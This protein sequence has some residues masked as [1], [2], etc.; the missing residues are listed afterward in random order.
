MYTTCNKDQSYQSMPSEQNIESTSIE[1]VEAKDEVLYTDMLSDPANF[2]IESKDHYKPE[3]Y[4]YRKEKYQLVNTVEEFEELLRNHEIEQYTKYN[5]IKTNGSFTGSGDDPAAK[6]RIHWGALTKVSSELA[7]TPYLIVA[8]RYYVCHL[9]K[10][11]YT[12]K[13]QKFSSET[14]KSSKRRYKKTTDSKKVGCPACFKVQRLIVFIDN[15][16]S[17]D[18]KSERARMGEYI[19]RNITSVKLEH[20][21]LFKF[22][23]KC[24]HVNHVENRI[25]ATKEPIDKAILDKIRNLVFSGITS[26]SVIS[27]SLQC[28]VESHIKVNDKNRRRFFPSR[29]DIRRCVQKAR[30]SL[31]KSKYDEAKLI[32]IK[33]TLGDANTFYFQPALYSSDHSEDLTCKKTGFLIVYQ[34]EEMKRLYNLYGHHC[35]LLDPVYKFCKYSFVLYFLIIQT[36]V[37]YQVIGVFL[38][39][40]ESKDSII[41]ALTVIF[42][43]NP[44]VIPKYAMTD[45]NVENIKALESFFSDIKVF[46]PMHYCE[47]SWNERFRKKDMLSVDK[48]EALNKMKNI[49]NAVTEDKVQ[50]AINDMK[51][52]SSPLKDYFEK[53]WQKELKKWTIA[54]RPNDLMFESNEAV[55]RLHEELYYLQLSKVRE[56]TLSEVVTYLCKDLIP[57]ML[58]RYK[59]FNLVIARNHLTSVYN[60]PYLTKSPQWFL[61]FMLG[62][63]LLA[64]KLL[65]FSYVESLGDENFS[66]LCKKSNE[67]FYINFFTEQKRVTCSCFCFLKRR[68]I[69][70]HVIIVGRFYP[71]WNIEKISPWLFDHPIYK[72]DNNCLESSL[73]PIPEDNYINENNNEIVTPGRTSELLE[74]EENSSGSVEFK[75]KECKQNLEYLESIVDELEETELENFHKKLKRFCSDILIEREDKKCQSMKKTEM[76][77]NDIPL[78]M[79]KKIS[80]FYHNIDSNNKFIMKYRRRRKKEPE[81]DD[82]KDNIEMCSITT[83][84]EDDI[85][86]RV[87]TSCGNSTRENLKYF[88]SS[89]DVVIH[90][91][92]PEFK[93]VSQN[94]E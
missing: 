78:P 48:C 47:L 19:R 61:D 33:S 20:K 91:N 21:Y 15:K 56:Y 24:D 25:A 36:N 55:E 81:K 22:P 68:I 12:H 67:K 63:I 64:D 45:N 82:E 32:A 80:D 51:G 49:A 14:K 43:W 42:H 35:I 88:E 17:V 50:K 46:I 9:G 59:V 66:L 74:S 23:D 85:N 11:Y 72:L 28:Y 44:N 34:N 4:T 40:S 70:K 13:L 5:I 65:P 79:I 16:L 54:Y 8:T 83:F 10:C 86:E 29:N 93:I 94:I 53:Y 18:T 38:T 62:E 7:T 69:C 77:N 39:D 26:V 41:D 73:S 57:Q 92:N 84:Y 76:H 3:I 6:P 58:H 60:P 90:I 52:W 37:S 30:E 31:R 27:E 2:I 71:G 75:K 87:P 1:L 89:S